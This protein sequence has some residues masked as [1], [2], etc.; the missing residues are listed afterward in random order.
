MV[1]KELS[2][3]AVELNAILENTSIE[4]VNKIPKKIKLSIYIFSL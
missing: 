3:A 2:E 1:S 4:L